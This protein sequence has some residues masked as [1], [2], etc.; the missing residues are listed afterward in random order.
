MKAIS[1]YMICTCHT[2]CTAYRRYNI[3]RSSIARRIQ[4]LNFQICLLVFTIRGI[5]FN[6][7]KKLYACGCQ[8]IK[9]QSLSLNDSSPIL[10]Q[11]S[12]FQLLSLN[13]SFLS[14]YSPLLISWK[15]HRIESMMYL[16]DFNDGRIF[17]YF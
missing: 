1:P 5:L 16:W 15:Y 11:L 6:K 2:E 8:C 4:S 3:K 10:Y 13:D 12:K 14:K 7:I 17:K 9:F